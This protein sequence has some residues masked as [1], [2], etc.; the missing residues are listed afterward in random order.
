MS[1]KPQPPSATQNDTVIRVSH[2]SKQYRLGS[3][4]GRT[5]QADLQSWWARVRGKSDPNL[6]I[7]QDT[8]LVGKRFWAL[9]DVSLE[10]AR[11]ERVGI[12]GANGAGKST[13]LKLLSRI[14]A[15]SEGEI[16]LWGRVS[17]MLEVGTGFHREMTGR[18]NIYLNGAILGMT[19]AEIDERMEAIVDF[20]EV[21]EFIDT[22]V[23]RYSSGMFV[24]LAF[25]VAAHLPSE[26]MIMDEVLA[27]GDMAFQRKC[28]ERMRRAADE[29]GRTV[30]YVS[31]N[32]ETIRRLCDRCV[33]MSEG[34]IIFGG[35]V[36]EGI[37]AYMDHALSENEV[38][39]N[40][41]TRPHSHHA[42]EMGV[43]MERLELVGKV[44]PVYIPGE[45]LR[46]RLWLR[47][48]AAAAGLSVRLTL[49]TQSDVGLGTSWSEPF[50]VAGE[51]LHEVQLLMATSCL[52][53]GVLYASVGVYATDE[54]GRQLALDHVTRAFRLE[55]EGVP[56]WDVNAHGYVELPNMACGIGEVP[57]LLTDDSRKDDA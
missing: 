41:G 5:L 39:I 50:D 4:G 52:R 10:V 18:E 21:R 8:R 53:S 27:V 11:G 48:D 49:R 16:D 45:T 54:L 35:D 36:E 7:G 1:E 22:P 42:G 46:L 32:M 13:L 24:K 14:T 31:H 37:G 3:I 33:V 2:V 20:S 23:K 26:I 9:H 15:P 19:R 29:E 6:R 47:A 28:L 30:L 17:S 43:R 12:I 56:T 44:L 55:F 51:G 38:D 40:L 25:A 34:R 57:S